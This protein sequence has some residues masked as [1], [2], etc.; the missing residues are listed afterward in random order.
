[1]EPTDSLTARIERIQTSIKRI[2]ELLKELGNVPHQPLSVDIPPIP[3]VSAEVQHEQPS[4]LI[5]INF[6]E[7]H[8]A[9]RPGK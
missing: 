6:K 7:R 8:M 4:N 9:K 1:M 2:N 3:Q 5:E